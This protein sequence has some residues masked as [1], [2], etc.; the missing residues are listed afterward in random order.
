MLSTHSLLCRLSVGKLQLPAPLLF[1]RRRRSRRLIAI[2]KQNIACNKTTTVQLKATL[3]DVRRRCEKR[4]WAI[5]TMRLSLMS[6]KLFSAKVFFQFEFYRRSFSIKV[7]S[8]WINRHTYRQSINQS[9]FITP[10]S[11]TS[12]KKTQWNKMITKT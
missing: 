12:T 8:K 7:W 1:N 11:S 9:I 10:N 4:G 3:R 5:R 2:L 6:Q